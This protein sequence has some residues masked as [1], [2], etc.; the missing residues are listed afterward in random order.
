[1][2]RKNA[3]SNKFTNAS[4]VERDLAKK[5]ADQ[6]GC[7]FVSAP[8][9]CGYDAVFEK[10]GMIS[11]V[12]CKVRTFPHNQYDTSII[13]KK[14]FDNLMTYVDGKLVT[15]ILYIMFFSDDVALVWNLSNVD[16]KWTNDDFVKTTMGDRS[17]VSKE[18][19]YL[20]NESATKIILK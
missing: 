12:E 1:M 20:S 15:K 18:V 3:N 10:D 2:K 8:H 16:A 6:L 7:Q 11:V 13:E 4:G 19:A 17:K 9:K 14:K 5:L